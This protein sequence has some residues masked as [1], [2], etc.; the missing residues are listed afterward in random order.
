GF[1][2]HAGYG[3]FDSGLA[4]I[5]ASTRLSQQLSTGLFSV[6]VR[7]LGDLAFP[8]S[9]APM[10]ITLRPQVPP[11]F[12]VGAGT[13]NDPL[14]LLSLP[15]LAVDFYVWSNERYIRF[16]T[17]EGDISVALDV[18]ANGSEIQLAV[19]EL[20]VANETVT[21]SEILK[22]EPEKLSEAITTILTSFAGQLLG[23][24]PPF[25]LP[26][27]MGFKLIVPEDGILG[28]EQGTDEFLAIFAD[29][30]F[31]PP[32][33]VALADTE[34]EI[35]RT[36]IDSEALSLDGFDPS[37]RPVV[38]VA[39]Q[40]LGRLG[41]EFE[42]GFRVDGGP[43]SRWSANPDLVVDTPTLML[44]ARHVIE[45]RSRI[46]GAPE[47]TDLSPAPLEVVVDALAPRV[48]VDAGDDSLRITASDLVAVPEELTFRVHHG[49]QWSDWLPLSEGAPY[50]LPS[51]GSLAKVEV[52][53]PSGN[54]G[55]TQVALVRGLPKGSTEGC[56]C[57]VPGT[58]KGAPGLASMLVLGFLALVFARRRR[59]RGLPGRGRWA[60]WLGVVGLALGAM[61]CSCGSDGPS[62]DPCDGACE[63]AEGEATQGSTCCASTRMCVAYD[64]DALC[65]NGFICDGIENVVLGDS[66]TP[67]C[68]S[69][70]KKPP[71]A[72]GDTGT[73]MD[74]VSG[75]DG[76]LMVSGY[77]AGS[78]TVPLGDLV[79]GPYRED[80]MSV[81][82]EILE[83]APDD[84]P[85][86]N[87]P[88]GW[89]GGVSAAGPDVGRWTSIA[90]AAGVYYVTYY[91]VDN[92]AL[93]IA[94][95]APGAWK[96][97]E[98]D[99]SVDAGRYGNLLVSPSGSPTVAYLRVDRGDMGV[100]LSSVVVATA[101]GPT[102]T[103]EADW[104]K[105]IVASA[106]APCRAGWCAEG[107]TCSAKGPC[108]TPG[109]GCD[110]CA[111]G[112]ACV[113]G[114]C[115]ETI[116]G[117][118]VEDM[119]PVLGL[120]PKLAAT[121]S[122]L[123]LVYYDRTAG[124]IMGVSFDGTD[125]AQPFLIDGYGKDDDGVGDSGAGADLFVDG[126]GVWH[127]TYVDGT[128]ETLRYATVDGM[129]VQTE[130]VD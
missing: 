56:G 59:R 86:T 75:S 70:V 104:T 105:T 34:A 115:E 9:S 37:R 99:R 67:T 22:E 45:V 107:E 61:G 122:G 88:D 64:L 108:V 38:Y 15:E 20:T 118:Y 106:E 58:R 129:T 120:Y 42:Y 47:T 74:A 103:S 63:E 95:G 33:V 109:G 101:S 91:D 40:G 46:V 17:F 25:T 73:Y 112:L 28:V 39:A 85:I 3:L 18:M 128:E 26:E 130:V 114:V 76:T 87:D 54:V 84:A 127:V 14:L 92:R 6:L 29:L 123:A 10:A 83:G 71:V 50:P 30:K 94:I 97:H 65:D 121:A 62:P 126:S 78:A 93:K 113:A 24:L 119:P 77:S 66:C 1:L 35:T 81:D 82:W 49:G 98:I 21:N 5:A 7:S 13:E 68:A 19:G 51:D 60:L 96:I 44:Q 2:D 23:A 53:D 57:A 55:R 116:D 48:L 36:E 102:P 90:E 31:T 80:S 124:N 110:K 41:A 69:C 4:C 32:S 111:D 12:E 11:S 72:L 43:W 117:S 125:W 89:R 52:R 8:N 100:L 16:M 79:V 27:F